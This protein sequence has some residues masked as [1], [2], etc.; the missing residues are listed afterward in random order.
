MN[1]DIVLQFS[2]HKVNSIQCDSPDQGLTSPAQN[3]LAHQ[4]SKFEMLSEE[5]F[6]SKTGKKHH[7]RLSIQ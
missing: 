1:F 4:R 5:K 6:S 7:E 3:Q 2:K